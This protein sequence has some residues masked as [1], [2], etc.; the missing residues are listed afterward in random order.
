[1]FPP[2]RQLCQEANKTSIIIQLKKCAEVC[3]ALLNV[4][5][6]KKKHAK[7]L[8]GEMVSKLLWWLTFLAFRWIFTRDLSLLCPLEKPISLVVRNYKI[9]SSSFTWYMTRYPV[10]LDPMTLPTND[11]T[12]QEKRRSKFGLK[13]IGHPL[14]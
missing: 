2:F 11:T 1:M 12:L 6:W 9:A 13:S 7:V 14:N 4:N 5:L 8:K 10:G 3:Y